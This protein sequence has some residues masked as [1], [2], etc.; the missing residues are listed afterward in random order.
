ME[1]YSDLLGPTPYTGE[2][3]QVESDAEQ[4]KRDYTMA[5]G[6]DPDEYFFAMTPTH[7][8]VSPLEHG[9]Q[10]GGM[11]YTDFS[12]PHAYGRLI[13]HYR[14][15]AEWHV[16]YTNMSMHLIEQKLKRYTKDQG[17]NWKGMMDEEGMP[18]D[19]KSIKTS[20][21]PG[22]GEINPGLKNWKRD[23]WAGMGMWDNPAEHQTDTPF[24]GLQDPE[25]DFPMTQPR[26]CSECGELM[27]NYD[28]WRKHILRE[29]VNKDRRPPDS[30]QPVVDLDD[31]LPA[32]F[33]EAIRDKTV[34]RQSRLIWQ[35]AAAS[36]APVIPGPMP[37]IYDIEKDRIFVGH[38]GERHSDIPG[39]FTPGG[40]V[41]GLYDPKGNVQ[42][43][44]NT[45]MPYTTRHMVELWYALHPELQVKSIMLMVGDK[46]YKLASANIGHKVRNLAAA[47]P[48][49]WA[50]FKALEP[51]GNVYVVGGAVRDVVLGKTPK[52]I[53][54]M[55]QGVDEN[56]I[57]E[58][59]N[60]LPGRVDFT[61]KDFGVY[62]YRDPG[63]NEVEVALPRTERS[64]GAGHK[65]FEV[66]T[67]PYLSVGEDLARRDFT[68]NAMAVNLS[69]GDL[70][71]PHNGSEHLK[72]GILHTV[73]DRSFPDDPLRILRALVA[74]S[75]HNLDPSPG[76]FHD[77]ASHAESLAEL[78]PE[79]IQMEI[80]KIMKSEDPAKAI[81]LAEATGILPYIFPEV[82]ATVGFDQQNKHHER[83]LH[84]HLKDVLRRAAALTD[85]PDVRM[86]ALLHDI[87]KPA[88]QWFGP[89]GQAHYYL[90]EDGRGANHHEV[91]SDMA[92]Q[93]LSELRYPTDRIDRIGHLIHHHMFPAFS[94]QQGARKFINRV[95]DSHADDLL[96]LREADIGGKGNKDAGQVD[97]MRQY[98][99]AV[100]QAGEPTDRSQLAINGSD[101]IEAGMK[102]GPEMGRVLEYLTQAVLE[103]P[104]LN[105]RDTLLRMALDGSESPPNATLSVRRS[106]ILDPIKD[107]LDSAVFNRPESSDPDVKPKIVEWVKKKVYK[108][109]IDAGWPNPVKL[110]YVRMIMTGSLT[111]YQWSENSDFDVSLWIVTE[112]LPEWVRA[113]LVALMI[114]KAEGIIV[115]GTTHPLQVF[116]VDSRQYTPEDLYKKGVRS[117][118]DLDNKHWL[119][120]PERHRSID[121]HKT[122]PAI[123]QYAKMCED[124]VRILLR[125]DKYALKVYWHFLHMKRFRD[126]KAGHGD[127][128]ES[129]I[130]Y[131]WLAN[132]GLFPAIEEATGEHIS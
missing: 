123:V 27:L 14:W 121:V 12:K 5:P 105:D 101:L 97:L 47:D 17:W 89:D 114:E 74:V 6:R 117:A 73:S 52:D 82:Q 39:R 21:A 34:Q 108:I 50:V 120:F 16:E 60:Q 29:H 127:Y 8:S 90:S 9:E 116:V 126:M 38:P 130:V 85:D 13:L 77:M 41:E 19:Y 131:K 11:G 125:Y 92:R 94:S 69:T 25:E 107:S 129:N 7:V 132:A 45:D 22:I 96:N 54:L 68:G 122:Y 23:E 87:G 15:D 102:P 46:S 64:I 113:D 53:D 118:Y 58:A 91:G 67:N 26:T 81:D 110:K 103:D 83:V 35:L 76:T 36:S 55:V 86:A 115:P 40:I 56:D 4:V 71:D 72:S 63:G 104:S 99:N 51:M 84:D 62:R 128:S 98:V 3:P 59:L 78:P 42:I 80:D 119:V 1:K 111:T 10:F 112:N 49:A 124:R 57:R 61:G 32:G 43:K 20:A 2:D 33:N 88:S 75:R 18:M 100:R 30:P 24:Y 65:G 37:F 44:T 70:V 79:R 31:V 109:L 93:R 66:V 48:A 28:E 106:N 95:G